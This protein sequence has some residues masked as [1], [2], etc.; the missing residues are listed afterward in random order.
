MNWIP[1]I[2]DVDFD[3]SLTYAVGSYSVSACTLS[4]SE[5]WICSFRCGFSDSDHMQVKDVCCSSPFD[6][7]S[8]AE[9]SWNTW[10]P[11]SFKLENVQ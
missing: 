4:E 2:V 1:V 5:A 9:H 10:G 8:E 3:M 6:P 11:K 7:L